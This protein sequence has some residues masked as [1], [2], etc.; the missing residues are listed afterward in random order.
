MQKHAHHALYNFSTRH[1]VS[2]LLG[3]PCQ[4][5]A[6]TKCWLFICLARIADRAGR[7]RT[8]AMAQP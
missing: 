2:V 3:Y 7:E 6:A 4:T 8:I 5:M 1:G